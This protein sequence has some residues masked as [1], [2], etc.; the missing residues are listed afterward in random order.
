MYAPISL[1]LHFSE[2]EAFP[3][4]ASCRGLGLR[5]SPMS[6]DHSILARSRNVYMSPELEPVMIWPLTWFTSSPTSHEK[7]VDSQRTE[8][9]TAWIGSPASSV[10]RTSPVTSWPSLKAGAAGLE[11]T[12]SPINDKTAHGLPFFRSGKVYSSGSFFR[13]ILEVPIDGTMSNG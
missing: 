7:P 1:E 4:S 8:T 2:E 5:G 6:L 10:K 9:M 12:P 13:D 11:W 3:F